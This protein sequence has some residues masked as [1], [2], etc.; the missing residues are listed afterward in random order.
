MAISYKKQT[1]K[2][3]RHGVRTPVMKFANDP[4]QKLWD[5]FGMGQL[6][7]EGMKQLHEFGEHLRTKYASVLN[8]VYDPKRVHAMSTETPRTIQSTLDFLF[9]IFG[10][11]DCQ[12]WKQDL[13][14]LQ[15]IPVYSNDTA[16]RRSFKS[17]D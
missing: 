8:D 5:K 15:T 10:T 17:V 9:G 13:A 6:L 12:K 14:S 1:Q 7:P 11:D 2:V 3:F 4:H 16:V